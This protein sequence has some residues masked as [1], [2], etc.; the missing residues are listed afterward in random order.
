MHT[1]IQDGSEGEGSGDVEQEDFGAP[2]VRAS[3]VLSLLASATNPQASIHTYYSYTFIH[4]FI[5]TYI[6]SY[7][8]TFIHSYIHT[9]LHTLYTYIHI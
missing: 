2:Y 9:Y 8:H 3:R 5:H 6:R 4:T 1:Y 7:I